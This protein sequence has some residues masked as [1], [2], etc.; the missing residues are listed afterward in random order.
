MSDDKKN[1][2]ERG[3]PLEETRESIAARV[4]FQPRYKIEAKHI[5]GSDPVDLVKALLAIAR[6]VYPDAASLSLDLGGMSYVA[7]VDRPDREA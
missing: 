6:T 1:T 5:E 7:Y 2:P 3:N 4:H